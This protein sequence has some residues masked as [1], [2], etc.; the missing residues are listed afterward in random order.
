MHADD[1]TWVNLVVTT[2]SALAGF[3]LG[4]PVGAVAGAVIP[5]LVRELLARRARQVEDVAEQASRAAG[6]TTTELA[7][8]ARAN[9]RNAALLQE[10]LDA[11]FSRK[12]RRSPHPRLGPG[13]CAG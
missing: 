6:L 1:R 11:A 5:E 9:D 8:W 13:R 3:A 12:T 10:A 7:A 4:G 2:G